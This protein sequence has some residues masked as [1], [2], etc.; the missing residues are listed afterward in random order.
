VFQH[1]LENFKEL[2]KETGGSAYLVTG[3]IWNIVSRAIVTAANLIAIGTIIELIDQ[4]RW[5]NL[6][7][8]K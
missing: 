8:D 7:K 1:G 4:I 6:H 2:A 5:N 3:T